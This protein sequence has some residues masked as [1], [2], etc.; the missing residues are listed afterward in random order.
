M[1]AATTEHCAGGRGGEGGIIHCNA[2]L[3]PETQRADLVCFCVDRQSD[4]WT[5]FME[6]SRVQMCLGIKKI[7]F[8]LFG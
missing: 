7:G 4:E 2:S 5:D 8:I 6:Q 3:G 1:C